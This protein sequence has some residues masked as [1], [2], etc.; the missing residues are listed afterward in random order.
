[1]NL[2][3]E[4]LLRHLAQYPEDTNPET[5]ETAS[6]F[7]SIVNAAGTIGRLNEDF[8]GGVEETVNRLISHCSTEI[9]SI[10]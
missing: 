8:M 5:L 3:E 1:M 10:E 7:V 6:R 2:Y 9:E 4:R